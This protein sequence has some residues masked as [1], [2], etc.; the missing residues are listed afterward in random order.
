MKEKTISSKYSPDQLVFL[1]GKKVR[2]RPAV[3]A[4]IP[5][6]MKW[7]NE[8][9]IRQYIARFLPATE[10]VEQDWLGRFGSDQSKE[11][12][13][14]IQSPKKA[15]GTIGL[16]INWKDR[17]GTVGI[18]IGELND[19]EKGYGSDAATALLRYAFDTLNLRKIVWHAFSFNQRSIACA[20]K[21]GFAE[22]A[23]LKQM[24]YVNGKYW[25]EVILS[26][27]R[28]DVAPVSSKNK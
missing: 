13:L 3:E 22:E 28:E 16:S 11:V 9:E 26:Q 2:L 5:M 25:D 15:I 14:V 20:K 19:Q 12:F 23:V 24:R 10:K 4:D 6:L 18:Q 1:R 21:C 8:P 7:V 27:F 17:V